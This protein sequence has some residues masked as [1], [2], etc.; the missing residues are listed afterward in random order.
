[1]NPLMTLAE[2]V[3]FS[4]TD[5]MTVLQPV[6]DNFTFTNVATILAVV[7]GAASLLTLGWFGV[8]K[9]IRIIQ[10]A[11]KRGKVSV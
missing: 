7:V 5:I 10:T 1:M 11:L 8:R 4:T 9:V 6:L 3:P 2:V